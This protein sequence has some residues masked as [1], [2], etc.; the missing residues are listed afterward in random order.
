MMWR[1]IAFCVL[2]TLA[3]PQTPFVVGFRSLASK[4]EVAQ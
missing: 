3:I 4:T 1:L 2:G